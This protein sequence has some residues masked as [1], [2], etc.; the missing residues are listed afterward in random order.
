MILQF[1]VDRLEHTS[2]VISSLVEGVSPE[3][4]SWK[5]AADRWS[6][7]EVINH[8]HDEECDD[9]RARLDGTLHHPGEPLPPIDPPR[10]AIERKY[11]ERDLTESLGGFLDE[12]QK[13]L[14]WLRGLQGPN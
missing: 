1:Y 8:L 6:I 14:Q 11:N 4:A 12:R 3:Q 7:L 10:W 2:T 9:F 13:S 5:P